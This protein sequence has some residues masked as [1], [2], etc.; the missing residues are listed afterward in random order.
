M[1]ARFRATLEDSSLARVSGV[2]LWNALRDLNS[3]SRFTTSVFLCVLIWRSVGYVFSFV[4]PPEG[5][6]G[7]ISSV[8]SEE[9][10]PEVSFQ[11]NAV[12][13]VGQDGLVEAP[14]EGPRG[15]Q[16]ASGP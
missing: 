12:N 3:F 4:G 14:P 11:H 10:S 7:C 5:A 1:R 13:W 16:G 2:G 9:K 15:G 8:I 6:W